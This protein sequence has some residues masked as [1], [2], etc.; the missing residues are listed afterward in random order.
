MLQ[1]TMRPATTLSFWK[2]TLPRIRWVSFEVA[3]KIRED[4]SRKRRAPS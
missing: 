1:T 3:G 2:V 4:N